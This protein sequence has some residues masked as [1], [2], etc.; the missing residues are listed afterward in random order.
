MSF[1]KYRALS[2]VLLQSESFLG[3]LGTSALQLLL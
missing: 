2:N 1:E 3:S